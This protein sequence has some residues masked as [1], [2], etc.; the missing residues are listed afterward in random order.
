[1]IRKRFDE[2]DIIMLRELKWWDWTDAQLREA[3]PVLT[4]GNV[5]ALHDHWRNVIKVDR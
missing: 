5:R 4:S 3:I 1:V 2:P